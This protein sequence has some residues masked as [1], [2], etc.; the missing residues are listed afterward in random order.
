MSGALIRKIEELEKRLALLEKAKNPDPIVQIE[1]DDFEDQTVVVS[2][3]PLQ[4]QVRTEVTD[5]KKVLSQVRRE[6]G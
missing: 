3:P 6:H 5:D 1:G 2:N 4:D